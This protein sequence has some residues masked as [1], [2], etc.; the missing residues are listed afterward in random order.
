MSK[1]LLPESTAIEALDYNR[2]LSV[3]YVYFRPST[4]QSAGNVYGYFGVPVSEWANLTSAPSAGK[5]LNEVVKQGG[6]AYR[7]VKEAVAK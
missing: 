5:Y 7:M 2:E 6:Y 1:I 3:L 4:K